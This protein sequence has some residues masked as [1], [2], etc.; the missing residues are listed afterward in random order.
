MDD[1]ALATLLLP[2]ENGDLA[3][4]ERGPV[5]FLRADGTLVER[6]DG[7][8]VTALGRPEIEPTGR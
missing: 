1:P 7:D 2:F 8:T 4:P 3:W 5:P 6:A